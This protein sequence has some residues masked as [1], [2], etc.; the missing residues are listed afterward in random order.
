MKIE[1]NNIHKKKHKPSL[2]QKV[3]DLTYC[4]FALNE[5]KEAIGR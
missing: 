3:N 4:I 5:E 1:L 2:T